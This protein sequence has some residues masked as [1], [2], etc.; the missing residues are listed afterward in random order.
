M[1]MRP[2]K[3]GSLSTQMNAVSEEASAPAA[4][5]YARCSFRRRSQNRSSSTTIPAQP[6]RMYS[7]AR[8]DH[9]MFGCTPIPP[10]PGTGNKQQGTRTSRRV[11]GSLNLVPRSPCSTQSLAHPRDGAHAIGDAVDEGRRPDAHE[12]DENEEQRAAELLAKAHLLQLR[13]A[14]VERPE[15]R[16]R[17]HAQDVGGGDGGGEGA[18]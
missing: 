8:S 14:F 5:T 4:A 16:H 13:P 12:G 9:S 17:Q 18:A 3:L 1:S 7:G 11:P 2:A 6:A 10:H 15:E